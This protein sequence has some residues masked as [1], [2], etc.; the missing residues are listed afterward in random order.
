VEAALAA[1]PD[2]RRPGTSGPIGVALVAAADRLW[3]E[4]VEAVI[5]GAADL[6]HDACIVRPGDDQSHLGILLGVGDPG[7]FLAVFAS[8]RQ[9][10]RAIWVGESLLPRGEPSGRRLARAARSPMLDVLR[11]PLRLLKDAPV[12]GPLAR[13]RATATLEHQRA[14]HVR[15][16]LRLARTADR[17]VV[18]SRDGRTALLEY[19]LD[20]EAVPFGYSAVTAGPMT[21]PEIGVRDLHFVSVGTLHARMAERR[22]II[23]R[24]ETEE[25][26]LTILNDVWGNERGELLRRSRVVLNVGRTPGIFAG[27]R[28]VLAIAAGAVVVSDPMTDPYPFVAGVHFVEAPLEGLL[29]A[30]RELCADEPRR[31]LMVDAGQALLAGELTMGRCLGRALGIGADGPCFAD[32]DA[33]NVG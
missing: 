23:R 11:S 33:C 30:A 9:C 21:P 10:R 28:L 19:G 29:D 13:M 12:P 4:L 25:P 2:G 3:G 31:R 1:S 16:V 15:E 18:T 8:P 7:T 17:L 20:A 32:T 22:A 6:G 5:A 26:R 14:R 27:V 24:W